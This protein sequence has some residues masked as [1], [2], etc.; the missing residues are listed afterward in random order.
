MCKILLA[1]LKFKGCVTTECEI[2][3]KAFNYLVQCMLRDSYSNVL[4]YLNGSIIDSCPLLVQQFNLYIDDQ[5]IIRSRAEFHKCISLSNDAINPV[6]FEK[7]HPITKL[8]IFNA[9]CQLKHLG[10]NA[11]L[12]YLRQ[13]GI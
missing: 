7:N 11:M 2:K 9:H 13:G 4:E 12:N 10:V 6:L 5:Y 3:L 8:I 1:F